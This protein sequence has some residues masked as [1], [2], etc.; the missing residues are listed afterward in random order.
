MTFFRCVLLITLLAPGKHTPTYPASSA[1]DTRCRRALPKPCNVAP[2]RTRPHP[3]RAGTAY[4]PAHATRDRSTR[5]RACRRPS[6]GPCP[7]GTAQS[8]AQEHGTQSSGAPVPGAVTMVPPG[9]WSL[10]DNKRNTHT[11]LGVKSTP[12]DLNLERLGVVSSLHLEAWEVLEPGLAP[13][14]AGTCTVALRTSKPRLSSEP[15]DHHR[16]RSCLAAH[17]MPSSRVGSQRVA[18]NMRPAEIPHSKVQSPA[19][20][21]NWRPCA[22]G[23]CMQL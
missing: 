9:G 18:R 13:V 12:L 11:V 23:E 4:T 8:R 1:P 7:P 5:A 22:A 20:A 2:T 15:S 19:A 17:I 10:V 21:R 14:S 3:A 16:E 6:G